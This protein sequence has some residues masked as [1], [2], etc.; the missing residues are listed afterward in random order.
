MPRIVTRLASLVHL[1]KISQGV[2]KGVIFVLLIGICIKAVAA[3][4]N[5]PTTYEGFEG[6]AVSKV[7][8]AASPV[9]NVEGFRP[10]I[11]QKAGEPFS[12]AAIRESVGALQKTKLFSQVQVKIE[13]EQ[14]GVHVIFV[15][16]PAFYVGMIFFPGASSFSYA[17]MLQAVNI[18]EQT[19]FVEDLVTNGQGA[20]LELFKHDGFFGAKVEPETQRDEKHLVVNLIYHATL[21]KRAKIGEVT[22]QGATEKEATEMRAAL[23]SLWAKVKGGSL[24]RGQPF[25]HT[26]IIKSLDY[27]RP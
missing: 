8:I 14:S 25:T 27:L 19:P 4:E 11:K 2:I 20:L 3:Q 12:I 13:P 7:D 15:M 16:Q 26:R 18:P 17:R 5:Q 23:N 10:L 24:K 21:G 22:F 1:G 6:R 9:M